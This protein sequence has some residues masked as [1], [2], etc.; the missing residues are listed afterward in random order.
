MNEFERQVGAPFAFTQDWGSL[1][2]IGYNDTAISVW[3]PRSAE[4]LQLLEHPETVFQFQLSPDERYLASLTF[5]GRVTLWDLTTGVAM[6]ELT[7]DE[8]LG[9]WLAFS[10]QGDRLA[11]LL[12]DGRISMWDVT[13][14]TETFTIDSQAI[15]TFL[16]SPDGSLL[17]T[18]SPLDGLEVWD[19]ITGAQMAS[20]DLQLTSMDLN[21]F[22]VYGGRLLVVEVGGELQFWGADNN[23]EVP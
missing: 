13:G 18:V 23:M 1:V 9:D 15:G 10:P 4:L 17:V 8:I 19:A 6:A 7:N 21:P 12:S 5:E 11:L 2:V 3:D 20:M 16:F 14:A 22:F